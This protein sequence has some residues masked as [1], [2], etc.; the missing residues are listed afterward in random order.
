MKLFLSIL[1]LCSISQAQQHRFVD[2][3]NTA[4]FAFMTAAR[5]YDVVTTCR[6]LNNNS[7]EVFL[8][9]QSCK[10]VAL[11]SFAFSALGVAGAYTMHRTGH[12]KL[13]RLA[14]PIA[15]IGSIVG[16][17]YTWRHH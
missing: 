15:T 7:K 1:L 2:K 5:S 17:V 11:Y 9:T 16:I 8:P 13:E 3:Q 10:G 4:S 6:N 14:M 12:H